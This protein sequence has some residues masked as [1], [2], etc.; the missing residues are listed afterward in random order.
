MRKS[1]PIGVALGGGSFEASS[2]EP[3]QNV[4]TIQA[5][6]TVTI[7]NLQFP[8]GSILRTSNRRYLT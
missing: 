4:P 3:G 2:P 1:A 8:I 5:L 6:R 7:Q